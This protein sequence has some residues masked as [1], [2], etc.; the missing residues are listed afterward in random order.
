MADDKKEYK[1]VLNWPGLPKDFKMGH[2]TGIG[3]DTSQNIFLFHRADRKWTYPFPANP[4]AASTV[5][6][7]SRENGQILQSWGE[8]F[9]VMPHGLTVDDKNNVWVTDVALHQVFKFSDKGK[10]LLQIGEA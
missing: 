10:L 5:L 6:Q 7:I 9:F 8:N 2:V 4:I 1:E 3:I